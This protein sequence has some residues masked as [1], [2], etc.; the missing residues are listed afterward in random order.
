VGAGVDTR[1]DDERLVP[2]AGRVAVI[3]M[4]KGQAPRLAEI[5]VE[6]D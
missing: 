1:T 4:G 5:V 2:V 6:T 3:S